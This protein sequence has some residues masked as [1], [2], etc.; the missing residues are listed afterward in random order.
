MNRLHPE[1]VTITVSMRVDEALLLVTAARLGITLCGSVLNPDLP[2]DPEAG[3]RAI[4]CILV[5]DHVA[6]ERYEALMERIVM[7]VDAVTPHRPDLQ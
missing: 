7:S 4:K 1:S 5:M 6:P 2:L 3:E